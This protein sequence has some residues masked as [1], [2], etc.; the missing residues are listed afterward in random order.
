MTIE[1]DFL[2]LAEALESGYLPLADL[3]AWADQH[4]LDLESPPRWLLDVCVAKTCE[5]ALRPIYQAHDRSKELAGSYDSVDIDRN[6]LHLGF[7]YLRHERGDLT[8]AE[9]LRMAGDHADAA[10]MGSPSCEDCYY[11]LNEIDGG[12]PTIPSDRPLKDRV[13]ELFAPMADVARPL[14]DLLPSVIQEP[15]AAR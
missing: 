10:D 3:I 7:L 9:L 6:V 12:G 2:V 1:R 13:D 14:R 15:R 8:L 4:V 11:L 5:E